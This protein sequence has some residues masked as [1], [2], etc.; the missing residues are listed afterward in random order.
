MVE[1]AVR[2]R[3]PRARLSSTFP[4]PPSCPGLIDCHTHLG[5]RADRFDE[6]YKFKDT[7]IIAR[8]PR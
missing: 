8:S 4:R 1:L 2:F 5:G 7:P 3:F 6:I